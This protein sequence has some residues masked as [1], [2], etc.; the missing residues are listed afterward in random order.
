MLNTGISVLFYLLC[1]CGM[2]PLALLWIEIVKRPIFNML[3]VL[4]DI[5]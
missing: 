1:S 4:I 5:L 3:A 2:N